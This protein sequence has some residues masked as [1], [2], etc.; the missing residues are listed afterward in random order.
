MNNE[1]TEHMQCGQNAVNAASSIHPRCCSHDIHDDLIEKIHSGSL[2]SAFIETRA[3]VDGTD[4]RDRETSENDACN[5]DE[6]S[7]SRLGECTASMGGHEA[8]SS[9]K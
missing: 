6:T 9:Q 3:T 1:R 7:M 2:C 4:E 5:M 8:F